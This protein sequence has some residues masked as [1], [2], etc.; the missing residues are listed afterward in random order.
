MLIL[1][2]LSKKT[3]NLKDLFRVYNK[4][5]KNTLIQ[6]LMLVSCM[7]SKWV[8]NYFD[9][10]L[11]INLGILGNTNICKL[12]SNLKKKMHLFINFGQYK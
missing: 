1:V 5:Y 4:R 9:K 3:I 7:F 6:V 12:N 2:D 8:S 10:S 11:I